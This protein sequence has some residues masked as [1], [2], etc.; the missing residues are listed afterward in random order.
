MRSF[1]KAGITLI[2]DFYN[3]FTEIFTQLFKFYTLSKV[4][5]VL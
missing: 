5:E 2:C 4:F 1:I 3:K